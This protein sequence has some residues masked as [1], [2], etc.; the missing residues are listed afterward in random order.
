MMQPRGLFSQFLIQDIFKLMLI[1]TSYGVY[2][3]FFFFIVFFTP[4]P[5]PTHHLAHHHL[6]LITVLSNNGMSPCQTL[7]L[8]S[9]T[10]LQRCQPEVV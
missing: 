10:A 1:E 3:M 5:K 7:L 9:T 8:Q 4:T 2:I 6:M